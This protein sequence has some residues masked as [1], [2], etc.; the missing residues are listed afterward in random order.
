MTNRWRIGVSHAAHIYFGSFHSIA[1]AE[2]RDCL[3]KEYFAGRIRDWKKLVAK[4]GYCCYEAAAT[5]Q[6]S[7]E[8][9]PLTVLISLLCVN[10]HRFNAAWPFN[11]LSLHFLSEVL[12]HTPRIR[13]YEVPACDY[14]PHH[15]MQNTV[16]RCHNK[17]GLL[18]SDVVLSVSSKLNRLSQPRQRRL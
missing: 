7:G 9:Y 13:T 6:N 11:V 3:L 10:S 5:S 2:E 14:P 8:L 4:H 1:M 18:I 17:N 12:S 16:H 15:Q